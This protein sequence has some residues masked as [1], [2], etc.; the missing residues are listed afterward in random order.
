MTDP[1]ASSSKATPKFI[2]LIAALMALNAL[3]IDILL[4]AL[5]A[6]GAAYAVVEANHR[7][8][9]IG[10]YMLGFGIGQLGLGPISDWLGRRKPLLAGLA[11]YVIAA[12]AALAAPS[13]ETLI[14]LRLL[15]GLGAAATRVVTNSVVRDLYAGRA[16]AEIM[17]LAFMVFMIV[18]I[19]APAIGEILLLTGHWGLV[20]AFMGGLAVVVTFW[21]W[22]ALPETLPVE[23]RRPLTLASVIEGF[24]LV[25][26]NRMAFSY[27]VAG[28]FMFAAV[29][30]FITQ[31]QQIYVEIYG[32]GSLFPVAFAAVAGLMAVASFANARIVQRIGM[33]RLSHGAIIIHVIL[34]GILTLASLTMT[35][36][37]WLFFTL[38]AGIMFMFGWSSSNFNALSMEPLGAV[39]GTASSVFGFIQTVGGA[40]LGSY[41]GQQ[42]D[43]SVR[44]VA[45][46]YLITGLGALICCLV[47]EKGRLFRVGQPS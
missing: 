46:G 29:M 45:I 24:S 28:L 26:S 40:L 16:M 30:G 1:A 32:L 21:A 36:P 20:F 19:I 18:P 42:F 13:F 10:A 8:Y 47:A 39:A 43:M 14:A 15:Q 35:V 34:A 38:L 6:L 31:A 2:A 5:P 23:R 44:P 12:F 11:V 3:A 41:I 33:R 9:V 4:P 27:G 25:I 17:S 7:Q 22:R 37:F